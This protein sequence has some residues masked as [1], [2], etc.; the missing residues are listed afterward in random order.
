MVASVQVC[1]CIKSEAVK[2]LQLR[3]CLDLIF[4]AHYIQ[5]PGYQDSVISQLTACVIFEQH[6]TTHLL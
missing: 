1:A 5:L 4:D 2:S 3:N 6:D